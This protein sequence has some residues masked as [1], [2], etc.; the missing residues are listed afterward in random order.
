VPTATNDHARYGALSRL[1]AREIPQRDGSVVAVDLTAV[2]ANVAA[3]RQHI[4]DR[5]L[6][7]V[8]KADAYGLGAACLAPAIAAAG[9]DGLAVA[10]L[11]EA[12]ALRAQGYRGPVLL[13]SP[14]PRSLPDDP[15]LIA[16]AACVDDLKHLAVAGGRTRVHVKVDTGMGRLGLLPENM[17]QW[18]PLAQALGSRWTGIWTHYRQ[19]DEVG[20]ASITMQQACM[21]DVLRGLAA[22]GIDGLQVHVANSA[23][24]DALMPEE[25][26]VRTGLFLSGVSPWAAMPLSAPQPRPAVTWLTWLRAP[27]DVPAKTRVS[28][29]G[30]YATKRATRLAVVPVGYAD[31]LTARA[32]ATRFLW[33]RRGR[34]PV[35]GRATMDLTVVELA[36]A[37]D[38]DRPVCLLGPADAPDG[39]RVEEL[40]AWQARIPYEILTALGPR[41]LRCYLD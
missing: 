1:A 27:R 16:T 41:V 38:E 30:E 23:G 34:I 28:Y 37:P 7:A 15:E 22:A 21:R 32:P 36:V 9:A 35:R 29:H 19:S 31:G 39:V 8:V 11:H 12:D 24:L 4:G 40:A 17:A 18:L 26:A 5:F 13:L 3:V 14:P 25:T 6:W 10:R 2:A 20:D 33:T